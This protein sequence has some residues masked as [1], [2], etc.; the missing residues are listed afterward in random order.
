M[1]AFMCSG[2]NLAALAMM[3]LDDAAVGLETGE[4]AV[5]GNVDLVRESELER[6]ALFFAAVAEDVSECDD[7]HVP[8][9]AHGVHCSGLAAASAADDA[10]PED[11]GAGHVNAEADGK[12]GGGRCEKRAPRGAFRILLAHEASFG[13]CILS[14]PAAEVA[15][16]RGR[17]N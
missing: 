11:A 8:A 5:V 14:Q 9:G 17:R 6:S 1:A 15:T 4:D 13:G 10:H 3:S 7:P 2:W 16:L 12:P